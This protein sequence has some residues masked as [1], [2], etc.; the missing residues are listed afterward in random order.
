M[1]DVNEKVVDSGDVPAAPSAE[2]TVMEVTTTEGVVEPTGEATTTTT[3]PTTTTP[4]TTT[5]TTTAAAGKGMAGR[6]RGIKFDASLLPESNDPAEIR[7]QVRCRLHIL[8]VL[9]E[10]N[11]LTG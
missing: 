11:L 9:R 6:K 7:K 3:T 2:K 8:W 1:S 10:T 4:T 5:T